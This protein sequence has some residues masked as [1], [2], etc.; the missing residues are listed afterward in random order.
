MQDEASVERQLSS[1]LSTPYLLALALTAAAVMVLWFGL[2]RAPRY[3]QPGRWRIGVVMTA[4]GL[5]AIWLL[6]MVVLAMVDHPQLDGILA[7]LAGA[8]GM[9]VLGGGLQAMSK[10][11]NTP[12]A[13]Q[14]DG[15]IG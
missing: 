6:P 1:F 10:A 8:C 15:I 13:D 11:D 5:V 3:R 12:S 4:S 9:G 7:L 14:W 2:P